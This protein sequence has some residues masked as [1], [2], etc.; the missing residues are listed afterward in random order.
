MRIGDG[1]WVFGEVKVGYNLDNFIFPHILVEYT[2]I[3]AQHKNLK[4]SHSYHS[5]IRTYV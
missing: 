1:D 5:Y 2:Y 4:N 3:Y